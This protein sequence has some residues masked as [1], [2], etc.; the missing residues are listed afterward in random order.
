MKRSSCRSNDRTF[1]SQLRKARFTRRDFAAIVEHPNAR[2]HFRRAKMNAQARTRANRPRRT[3]QDAQLNIDD[4]RRAQTTDR[5]EHHSAF[6]VGRVHAGQI[7]RRA[8]TR[9]RLRTEV[10]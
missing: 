5:S 2:E 3:R 8:L 4:L 1:K 10:P 9:R 6:D 7:H